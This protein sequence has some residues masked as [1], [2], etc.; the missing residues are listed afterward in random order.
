MQWGAAWDWPEQ[1]RVTVTSVPALIGGVYKIDARRRDR[2]G[3]D[4]ERM[5]S[6][7]LSAFDLE[8]RRAWNHSALAWESSR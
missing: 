4:A 7:P 2:L 6:N 3:R 1:H 5:V 8:A